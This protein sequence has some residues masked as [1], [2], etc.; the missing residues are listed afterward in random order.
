MRARSRS[1]RTGRAKDS[2]FGQ[3][4]PKR[5]TLSMSGAVVIKLTTAGEPDL[6]PALLAELDAHCRCIARACLACF[7]K[8][9][10][11]HRP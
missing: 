9:A 3:I 1:L 2:R 8:V 7:A 10:P 4:P 6:D 11:A 5:A